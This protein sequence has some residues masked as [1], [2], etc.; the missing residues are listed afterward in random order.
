MMPVDVSYVSV[1][2]LA[3]HCHICGRDDIPPRIIS[4]PVAACQ[5]EAE[6]ESELLPLS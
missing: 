2:C 6:I 1:C 3:E 5:E 4:S